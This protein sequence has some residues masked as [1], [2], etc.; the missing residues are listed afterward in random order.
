MMSFLV[1]E[2]Q[3]KLQH[4]GLCFVVGRLMPHAQDR[5]SLDELRSLCETF[6]PLGNCFADGTL[7]SVRE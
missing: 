7:L 2:L 5:C 3:R 1:N 6:N 4:G